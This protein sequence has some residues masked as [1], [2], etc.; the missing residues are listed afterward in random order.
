M[1]CVPEF[2][3]RAVHIIWWLCTHIYYLDSWAILNT[4]PFW[5]R[6]TMHIYY[7]WCGDDRQV[8]IK[9]IATEIPSNA[10]SLFFIFST[11]V[12]QLV[13]SSIFL[14]F[15]VCLWLLNWKVE[16]C[17]RGVPP[18]WLRN[19][20]KLINLVLRSNI[21]VNRNLVELGCLA[22]FQ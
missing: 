14:S 18:Y 21:S 10:N 5:V 8:Q 16:T 17:P 15:V 20:T 13:R 1:H 19:S 9:I 22:N 6:A 4:Y 7:N 2:Y 3:C 11:S 12:L